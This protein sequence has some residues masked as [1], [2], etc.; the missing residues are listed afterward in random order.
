M[1]QHISLFGTVVLA[2]PPNAGKST[3]LNALLGQ[4]IAIVS[5]K[6]QTTR[7]RITGILTT[8]D[9]Q[10]IFL[11]TPG[12]HRVKGRMNKMLLQSAWAGVQAADIIV[13]VADADLYIK[14]PHLLAKEMAPITRAMKDFGVS[15]FI[16]LNKT[17]KVS[18][19]GLLLPVIQTL[20]KLWP[21]AQ[22]LPV[23]A[24]THSGLEDLLIQ[25]KKYL[26]KGQ[27]LFPKDQLSTLPLRFM[28]AEVIREKLF[29]NLHQELP[30]STAVEIENWEEHPK[31]TQ[32]NALIWVGRS[33]HKSIVIGKAG[34]NLK[35]IGKAARL[36]LKKLL[37]TKV[38]LEIW[39]KV[40]ERWTEDSTF[41]KTLGF[42]E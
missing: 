18:D 8:N 6:P 9:A 39:V 4:K 22:I 38:H 37:G 24:A 12:L 30:Y 20:S 5:P 17:D 10:I 32:I 31:L 3:L 13:I 16:A 11:D 28:A 41:L 40:K 15:F 23:S 34:A 42:G 29:L 7:N 14:K 33:S 27:A 25:I 19:K 35:A 2:G 36:E 21:T 26:P 1:Q